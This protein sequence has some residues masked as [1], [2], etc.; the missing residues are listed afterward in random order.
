MELN[1]YYENRGMMKYFGFMLSEH[2]AQIAN[3]DAE[4]Y[5][6]IPGK[7]EMSQEHI[8]EV[9]ETAIRNSQQVA[10]QINTRTPGG[11][12]MPDIVGFVKGYDEDYIYIDDTPVNIN[13]IR[14]IELVKFERWFE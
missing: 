13:L 11:N 9:F 1:R 5:L 12:F 3:D 7:E 10:I 4:R 6:V 14:H 8:Y 2:N